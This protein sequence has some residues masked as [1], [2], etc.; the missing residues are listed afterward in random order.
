MNSLY[1]ISKRLASNFRAYHK[2]FFNE[3][4]SDIGVINMNNVDY[5]TVTGAFDHKITFYTFKSQPLEVVTVKFDSPEDAMQEYS[6]II[7]GREPY[8]G[9]KF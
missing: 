7:N 8:Y 2:V 5:F 6:N 4:C 9:I 1:T 3:N